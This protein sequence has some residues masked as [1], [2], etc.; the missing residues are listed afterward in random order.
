PRVSFHR[1]SG[2]LYLHSFPT[3]RSSDLGWKLCLPGTPTVIL[4]YGNYGRRSPIKKH[5]RRA[6]LLR[7]RR[8]ASRRR[9]LRPP[10]ARWAAE[11]EDRKSTRLNSSHVEI[12]YAVFCLKKK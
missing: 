8:P 12:S 2:S 7:L 6:P 1:V 10:S 4:R 9:P 5:T 3:R 11:A